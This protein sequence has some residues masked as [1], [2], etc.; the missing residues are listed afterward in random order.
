MPSPWDSGLWVLLH[1]WG[2]LALAIAVRE[3][4]GISTRRALALCLLVLG[5]TLAL[6][7]VAGLVL[8]GGSVAC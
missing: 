1:A 7:F 6:L 4:F 8:V 3:A 2:T 5:V